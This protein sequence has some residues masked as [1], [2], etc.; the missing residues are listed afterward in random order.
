M[1]W[2]L[3]DISHTVLYVTISDVKKTL[4]E[5]LIKHCCIDINSRKALLPTAI[6]KIGSAEMKNT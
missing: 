1:R 6:G 5:K 4:Q 3:F 2:E